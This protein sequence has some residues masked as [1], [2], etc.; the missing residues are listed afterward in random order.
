MEQVQDPLEKSLRN[1]YSQM[2]NSDSLKTLRKKS[3]E[4]FL[5]LGLPQKGNENY[6]Y[7]RLSRLRQLQLDLP[8]E[9]SVEEKEI[10]KH[11][12]PECEGSCLVFVNGR[13]QANLSQTDACPDRLIVLS[14]EEAVR[15]YGAFLNN[16]WARLLED[17]KDPF[18][19]LNGALH[20]KGALLYLP[21]KTQLERPLQVLNILKGDLEGTLIQPRLQ[22]F[23][24]AQ[25][26]GELLWTTVNLSS[27]SYFLN[28][29]VDSSLEDNAQL[30]FRQVHTELPE[31]AWQF[32][33]VRSSLKRD[34]RFTG[35]SFSTGSECHREDYFMSLKG[36]NS[37]ALLSGAWMLKEKRQGHVN[38][39]MEH[40]APHCH[41]NQLFKGV[42]DENGRSSFIGK[43]YVHQEAQKTDAYQLNANLVLSDHARADCQP[44]LEI[45]AD[46]VK[47]SHGATV[48]QLDQ[49][50]LFYMLT[51]GCDKTE[52]RNLMLTGFI[53]EVVDEISTPSLCKQV[54]ET[55]TQQL[56]QR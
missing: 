18:S 10:Q 16:R 11:I 17:E 20:S 39:L 48:G 41:S 13:Y 54:D 26:E 7:L 19:L 12:L 27:S 8:Q 22:I 53:H 49:E 47:A 3:W 2:E 51:R 56:N 30:Q 52:A 36:E 23:G 9:V 31:S 35:T 34:S 21:P 45:F 50:Q 37:E 40:Q 25:S 42:V 55:L 38:V 24:G 46:D 32:I 43:V 1:C 44:N 6:R 4:R 14:L 5:N 33:A 15:P 28:A 29:V